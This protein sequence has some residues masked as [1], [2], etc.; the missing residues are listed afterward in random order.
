MKTTIRRDRKLAKYCGL[1]SSS[2][3]ALTGTEIIRVVKNSKSINYNKKMFFENCSWHS[4]VDTYDSD[5]SEGNKNIKRVIRLSKLLNIG[6]HFE[7]KYK[8]INES[9]QW[10]SWL[11]K[12]ETSSPRITYFEDTKDFQI[13][14]PLLVGYSQSSTKENTNKIIR[15]SCVCHCL[16]CQEKGMYYK[17]DE[18]NG[19]IV[20][21]NNKRSSMQSR[22]STLFN[23]RFEYICDK[24]IMKF[25]NINDIKEKEDY[26]S[27]SD[28]QTIELINFIAQEKENYSLYREKSIK[29]QYKLK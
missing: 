20:E 27:F 15:S 7:S 19:A 29:R 11:S 14:I 26:Y 28:L 24:H 12:R 8:K 17:Y 3:F 23:S 18:S 10:G 21:L 9:L 6:V 25:L 4:I 13:D 1:N 2:T 5:I 22:S 16:V